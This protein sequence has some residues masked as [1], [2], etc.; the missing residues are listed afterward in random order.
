M[1]AEYNSLSSRSQIAV[2]HIREDILSGKLRGG[3]KID[4]KRLTSELKISHIP[5]REALKQLEGEGYVEVINYSGAYVRKLSRDEMEDLYL[6][7]AEVEALAAG[8]GI[9]NLTRNDLKQ[10]REL[11]RKMKAATQALDYGQL[12]RL[13][14]EFHGT[15]YQACRRT[16]LL[17]LLNDLWNRSA[18]YRILGMYHPKRAHQGLAEHEAML[19][20][21][22]QGDVDALK[23]AVRAN[24]D[25]T[26]KYLLELGHV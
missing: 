20:A 18:R 26:R 15:I 17:Q 19:K 10:L 22:E 14:R 7:R 6:V 4:Q 24:V 5:L 9:D 8:L 3:A 23:T 1:A 16:H 21:C 2:D 11:F 25:N 13:N 12:L